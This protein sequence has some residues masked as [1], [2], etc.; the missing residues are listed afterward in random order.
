MKKTKY[1][2]LLLCAICLFNIANA[3]PRS[4]NADD[5]LIRDAEGNVIK[6]LTQSPCYHEIGYNPDL[7]RQMILDEYDYCESE[8]RKKNILTGVAVLFVVGFLWLMGK[9]NH[10]SRDKFTGT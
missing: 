8:K 9:S 3:Q 7:P 2:T 1:F 4:F 10:K 5:L 6:D